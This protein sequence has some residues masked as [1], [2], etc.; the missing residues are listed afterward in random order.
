[1]S[2]IRKIVVCVLCT[3]PLIVGGCGPVDA[4]GDDGGDRGDIPPVVLQQG[5]DD[6]PTLARTVVEGIGRRDTARLEALRLTEREHN[7]LV[8]PRLPAGQPPQNF[9]VDI[10]WANIRTRNS[11]A[12]LRLFERYGGRE[13]TFDAVEC[14]GATERFDGFEVST[15][16]WTEFTDADGGSYRAQLF[17]H[18]ISADGG[19]KVFRYYD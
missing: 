17:R 15:D 8:F 1:M 14:L 5:A 19:V 7:E 4:A 18:V 16:C 11:V 10:A 2:E 12:V 9:P 6:L 3:S 13:L